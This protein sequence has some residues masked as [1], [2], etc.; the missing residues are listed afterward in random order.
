LTWRWQIYWKYPPFTN[1]CAL[2]WL[3]LLCVRRTRSF[4]RIVNEGMEW[5]IHYSLKMPH[6]SDKTPL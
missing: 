2:I 4:F 3:Q 5:L 6:V 1:P